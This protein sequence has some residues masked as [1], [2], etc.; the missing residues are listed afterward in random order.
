MLSGR[1]EE[2][3][4]L[5]D[6]YEVLGVGRQATEA[7]IKLAFRRL[8]AQH[9]PDRNPDDPEAQ[10]RF[11]EINAAHQILSDPD[12]RATFDRFGEAAFRPGGRP[13]PDFVDLGGLDGI[14][15]DI[16]GAF[17]LRGSE[18]GDVKKSLEL[19]FEE[20]ARGAKKEIVYERLDT[21]EACSGR[22]AA[23]GARVETCGACGGRGRVR[24]Q[25]AFLPI[26]VERP[27]SRCKGSGAI[28]SARCLSCEGAGVARVERKLS[29]DVPA[30]IE[31][32]SS[33]TVSGAGH[34]LQPHRPAGDLELL[35]DVAPHPFF[36]RNGDDVVCSVPVTFTQAALGGEVE[37]PT[38]DGKIKLRVPPSSQPG[39]VLRV[40]GRGFPRHLRSGSG[41]QL[42]EIA[43][44]VPT[45][46]TD[47]A[48]N[49]LEELGQELGEDV[50]PQRRSFLEKL[51]GLF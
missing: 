47:R 39:T 43:V 30:G 31:P 8:A 5:R 44:E 40:R 32:G 12:K 37:V 22:G 33:K 29:V 2:K 45:R 48:K 14:F 26:A 34:R 1:Y 23:P 46:L 42:V 38:L 28:P 10:T 7:E 11:K 24:Y 35:I 25:Q 3:R 13:G 18:R 50:Q 21:C 6:P 51:K 15:G 4:P 41:D 36:R 49:L 16:L 19:T 27:C 17:G 9:H 20:S